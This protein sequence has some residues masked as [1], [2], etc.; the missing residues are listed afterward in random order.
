MLVA[1]FLVGEWAEIFRGLDEE[2]LDVLA[3]SF[4][5]ENCLKREGL[6]DVLKE[7]AKTVA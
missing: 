3:K 5:F 7:N 1:E 6:N 4:R 2:E